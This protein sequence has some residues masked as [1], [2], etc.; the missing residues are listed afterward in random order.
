MGKVSFDVI[1]KFKK[2]FNPSIHKNV[3]LTGGGALNVLLNDKL[4]KI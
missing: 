4:S 1:E 3:C 2:D